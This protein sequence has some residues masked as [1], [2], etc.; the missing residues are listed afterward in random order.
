MVYFAAVAF[1][2][3]SKPKCRRYSVDITVSY[4]YIPYSMPC[5]IQNHVSRIESRRSTLYDIAVEITVTKRRKVSS[6]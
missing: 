2:G 5:T 4:P 1:Y 3:I 6:Q